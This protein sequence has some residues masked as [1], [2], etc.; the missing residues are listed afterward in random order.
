[1]RWTTREWSEDIGVD[2]TTEKANG[3]LP[4]HRKKENPKNAWKKDKSAQEKHE[5]AERLMFWLQKH[6]L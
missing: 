2:Q 6:A 1:V 5:F 4:Q 3:R